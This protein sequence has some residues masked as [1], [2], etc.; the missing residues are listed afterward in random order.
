VLDRTGVAFAPGIDFG[1]HRAR[2]HVRMAYAVG[3]EKLKDGVARLRS[4]L[5]GCTKLR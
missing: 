3:L 5:D 4:A 2:E 1:D